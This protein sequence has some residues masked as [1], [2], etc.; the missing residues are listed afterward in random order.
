[1]KISLNTI[2]NNVFGKTEKNCRNLLAL[3]IVNAIHKNI[4]THPLKPILINILCVSNAIH[5]NV[6]TLALDKE[7]FSRRPSFMTKPFP[8]PEG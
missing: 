2:T 6:P 5:N 1:M 3:I 4:P 8:F 7:I